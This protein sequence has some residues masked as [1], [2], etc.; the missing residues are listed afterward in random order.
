MPA[1]HIATSQHPKTH[2]ADYIKHI[3]ITTPH[4][5]NTTHALHS[6][7]RPANAMPQFDVVE[8][9]LTDLQH[10]L[11]SGL[12]TSVDLVVQYLQRISIYD[13]R[14]L[15][16]NSTP[17]L[18]PSVFDEAIASD[19]RR[20]AGLPPLSPLDGIPYTVKDSYK[21]R[22][23][24]VASGAPPLKDLVSSEDA[25]T[26][27]RLRAAGAVL[28]GKTNMPPMAAGGMQRGVYGRAES[29]YNSEYLAAAFGSGSSNGSGV[30][31]AASFAAFG[32]GEETVS[33]GRSPASNNA[34]VAYTPSRGNISIRGNWPLYP[35]CD[36][37]V[38]HARTVSD[39]L[40]LLD[41]IAEED[42]VTKGDFWRNQTMVKLPKPWQ[43]KPKSFY[44][45]QNTADTGKKLR[46]A[47]PDMYTVAN[48]D[49]ENGKPYVS[50][51]IEQLWHQAKAHLEGM[52]IQVVQVS[53]F[54]LVTKYEKHIALGSEDWLGL[55]H[56]W[57][58]VER[59]LLLALGWQEFLQDNAD[60]KLN[61]LDQFDTRQLWPFAPDDL[62]T[63][64][65]KP[66]NR[67]NWGDLPRLVKEAASQTP[68][69]LTPFDT[70]ELGTALNA[71]EAMRKSLLEDWMDDNGFDFVVFPAAGDVGRA[72]AD[73]V[74]ESA[75]FAWANGVKYSNGNQPLRHLGVP[76]VTVP[77]G[78]IEG[79]KMPMGLTMAGKAY[80]DVN[81]LRL[82][83]RY[84][85]ATMHR[86]KPPLTPSLLEGEGEQK[87]DVSSP[88]PK[89]QVAANV[90]PGS[91]QGRISVSV[92]GSVV[93]S[94]EPEVAVYVDGQKLADEEVKMTKSSEGKYEFSATREVDEPPVDE[95]Q[96]RWGG[97]VAKDATLVMVTARVSGS[98]P[99]AWFGQL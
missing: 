7:S 17:I 16:L 53:D 39:L 57:K 84:E 75:A 3:S 89:L 80:D 61:S 48:L 64:H 26:V 79:K 33:S 69:V 58:L 77:M 38:P 23:L 41:V 78:M 47:A 43:D 24:T 87:K 30:A 54:P 28:I 68:P 86:C 49:T 15:R 90:G 50:K 32:L 13:H 63:C 35:T 52:G 42:N 74:P 5:H 21:V 51:E 37:V 36:V 31:T 11:S 67:I 22:G 73:K 59:G 56:D 44:D 91:E 97:R 70:P 76:S 94:D 82:A 34:V 66:E 93:A 85:Q 46:V 8:A 4:I 95:E 14:G 62:Q 55:P 25:F 88:R 2:G 40:G 99:A 10:A 81:I 45:L 29:P 9:S 27:A 71:L 83:Y 18:N 96:K 92:T 6:N 98:R 12:V 60:P 1:F 72:D 65:S 19:D 20:A